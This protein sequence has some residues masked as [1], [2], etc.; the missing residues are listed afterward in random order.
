MIRKIAALIIVLCSLAAA[1]PASAQ[2]RYGP[3]VGVA[4]TDLRF[5]QDLF[6]VDKT[7]GYSAGIAAEMMFPGIGFGID[8]GLFYEN[9]GAKLHLGEKE[10]WASQ[11]LGT[12][13]MRLH[14]IVLPLHLR[15]KYTRLNGFEDTL[16]PFV[17]AGPSFGFIAGHSKVG[18]VM[19]YAGADL[20]IDFGVGAEI[21]RNW[22][23][24]ASYTMG[25]TYAL[26]AKILTNFSAR[27]SIWALRVAYLF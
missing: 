6:K 20:G 15:F 10:M 8:F 25:M 17:Y 11:G 9:R 2:F 1:V 21:F 18:D 23:V 26:K 3:T 5:K 16:A 19:D 12:E 24:S 14:S 7:V 4:M 22:Q 13:N 27:N